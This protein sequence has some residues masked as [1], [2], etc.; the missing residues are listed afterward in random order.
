M[1]KGTIAWALIFVGIYFLL[2]GMYGKVEFI[3]GIAL[4]MIGV[5]LMVVDKVVRMHAKS[6]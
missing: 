2:L 6:K 3:L 1:N 5:I 4:I